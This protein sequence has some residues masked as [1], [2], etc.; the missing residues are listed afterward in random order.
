MSTSFNRVPRNFYGEL[1]E[2]G[3]GFLQVDKVADIKAISFTKVTI[4]LITVKVY[5]VWAEWGDWPSQECGFV[6]AGRVWL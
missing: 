2:E 1:I 4:A 5:A 3:I 6:L